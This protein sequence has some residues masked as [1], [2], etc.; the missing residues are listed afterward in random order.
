[1]GSSIVSTIAPSLATHKLNAARR[2]F[3]PG[4]SQGNRFVSD[5][6][7]SGSRRARKRPLAAE[8]RP[9]S[10]DD[11]IGQEHI[12]RPGSQLRRR[13]T[14]GRIGSVVLCGPSGIGKTTIARAI[15]AAMG[16]EFRELHPAHNNVADIKATAKE[17]EV[18]DVLV[19]VDE[20]HRF[21]A[22]QQDHLLELTEEGVFDLVCAT[23]R[24]P[25]HSLDAALVSRSLI[26]R[27]EPI[28]VKDMRRVVMRAIAL[29]GERG[30]SLDVPDDL[31][32]VIAARAGGDARRAVNAV[33]SLYV[34]TESGAV[35][36]VTHEMV[37][38]IYEASP[39]PYDRS[40]DAH[41]DVT[42]A[43]VKSMRGSDP[44]ATL[45]W[46]ARLIH[47]GEDPAFIARRILIHASED[48]GLADNAA[49]QTAVAALAAVQH[50][51]YPE[52][53]IVLAHAALHIALAPK[54]NSAYRGIAE[55]LAYVEREALITVPP[56]LKDTHYKGAAQMG[57]KGYAFPH[58][59]P[60][61]WVPQD[62][63]PG[64]QPGRFYVSDARGNP[65]FE[66]RA[67]EH[68]ERVTGKPRRRAF[69]D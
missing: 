16:K 15:G 64:I 56:H 20:V 27:L 65:T 61:G 32:T 23:T 43:F 11:I 30:V 47:S 69:G 38:E 10:L 63:A 42:S 51:G 55:A 31:V 59:D 6:F 52:A 28:S 13:V 5:L 36:E 68:W 22:T 49:L 1:M 54:S 9:R 17:A 67:N 34:G 57:A 46:L 14:A 41:Y 2:W 21:N 7:S 35:V 48:V 25:F 29:V 60:R 45:Y 50:V 18:R 12:L 8:I 66:E 26:L 24:N 4:S 53:R 44:D 58:D 40:G 37:E 39:V 3:I 19:F 33:E 62:Y